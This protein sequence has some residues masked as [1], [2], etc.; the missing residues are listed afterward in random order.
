M[1]STDVRALL[2]ESIAK[3]RQAQDLQD[4]SIALQQQAQ[5]TAGAGGSAPV[6]MIEAGGSLLS[7]LEQAPVPAT[8]V[9]SPE[10][11]TDTGEED[12][13][14]S[15]PVTIIGP[16]IYGQVDVQAP[17]VKLIGYAVRGKR[18]ERALMATGPRLVLQG[19]VLQGS[20]SGQRRGVWLRSTGF[21]MSDS[22]V[23]DI[24]GV[25]QE[26]QAV[27]GWSGLHDVLIERCVL[28][29]ASEN[30]LIGG[31][32][33]PVAADIP[34]N[35]VVRK[36]TLRKPLQ[37]RGKGY[38]CKNL[39]ELK[40]CKGAILEDCNL[41]YSWVD[42]Q[43]GYGIVLTVQNQDKDQPETTI[44]DVIIRR[45]MLR[46]LAGAVQLDARDYRVGAASV[47]MSNVSFEDN[48]FED[49]SPEWGANQRTFQFARGFSGL[50]ILR[51]RF[52]G[53]SIHSFFDFDG[54]ADLW[55]NMIIDGNTFY[56]GAYGMKCPDA[57]PGMPTLAKYSP[58]Y[59][60][61]MNG[62]LRT[63][64]NNP[65]GIIYPPRTILMTA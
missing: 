8:I 50:R 53:T 9:V 16:A 60:W 65:N 55:S 28:E 40:N 56:E 57:A 61:T 7:T 58:G 29:S 45:N 59:T 6:I 25:G 22:S 41:D 20:M 38:K 62:V 13:V 48:L 15:K 5:A 30:I 3:V 32:G 24:F 2:D 4:Q 51:N 42:G 46:H 27:G 44:S 21:R 54:E 63:V 36:S 11:L 43:I 23:L 17:D 64:P 33:C 10:V 31:G 12:L 49:I 39:Y 26:T 37:W 35:V 1:S 34:S 47:P 52:S 19:G 14:I 18:P